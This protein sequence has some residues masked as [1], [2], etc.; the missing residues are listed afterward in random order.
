[1]GYLQDLDCRTS[2]PLDHKQEMGLEAGQAH[3]DFEAAVTSWGLEMQTNVKT[4]L[5]K[6]SA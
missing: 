2:C 5:G 1:M 3:G 6:K 4:A